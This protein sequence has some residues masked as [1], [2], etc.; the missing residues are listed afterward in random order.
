MLELRERQRS[1]DML[2]ERSPR[3]EEYLSHWLEASA[4]RVRP[5]T[6]V[7]Y[8]GLVRRHILPTLGKIRLE[9]L[10]AQH[11]E[12]LVIEKSKTNLAPASV[13]RI[14]QVL[15][16]ALNHAVRT[17]LV[18]RNVAQMVAAPRV[19]SGPV[20]FLSPDEARRLIKVAADHRLGPLVTL[21]LT[22]G[23]RQGEA[24]GLRWRNVDLELGHLSVTHTLQ[25]VPGK[26][27]VLGEPKTK[28]SRRRL[29]L[30]TAALLALREER[31]RQERLRSFAGRDWA[32]L[33]L[34]FATQMGLPLDPD[35][36]R[37]DFKKM[38]AESRAPAIRFHD[39]RHSAATLLLAEGVHPRVVMEML[40]HSQIS[41]TL[42]TYSH[43]IPP[44]M[45]EAANAMDRVLDA[46][47]P[48]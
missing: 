38:L 16:I 25:R 21:C 48:S 4:P 8:S 5:K 41:V 47:G 43:V 14:L 26:G 7:S 23:L 19:T 24:L 22:T 10:K 18:N 39:L 13:H 45:R 30:P 1:G 11:V 9:D 42:N 40:G 36:M 33:D 31:R 17:G 6:A 34:V 44:L 27:L 46:D 32:D 2:S 15:R 3:L 35:N 12:R 20:S 29:V 28:G 37:R